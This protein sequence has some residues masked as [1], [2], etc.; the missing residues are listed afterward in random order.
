MVILRPTQRLRSLLP[1]SNVVPANS[2]TALGDW[3]VNRLVVDRRP[4]L[5]LV[6]SAS[7][8]P[9]LVPARDVRGLSGRLAGIVAARLNRCG[10]DERTISAETLAMA[11]I[12]VGPTIDRSVL[13]IMVDFAKS[14]PYHLEPGGWDEASLRH[15]EERLAETPCHAARSFDGVVFPDKKAAEVLRAKWLANTLAPTKGG[16]TRAH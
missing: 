9:M 6:S 7:L 5:L 3:Y 1:A 10:I 15:V 4:L 8:L 13:G 14:I 12:V 2:D 11:S 16:R